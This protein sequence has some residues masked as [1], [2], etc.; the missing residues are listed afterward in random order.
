MALYHSSA[1]VYRTP[2]PT[3]CRAVSATVQSCCSIVP[4]RLLRPL[5][6]APAGVRLYRPSMPPRWLLLRARQPPLPLSLSAPLPSAHRYRQP[7]CA[8]SGD[9]R[10]SRA[11]RRATARRPVP[12][13]GRERAAGGTTKRTTEQRPPQRQRTTTTTCQRQ[14]QREWQWTRTTSWRRTR[15]TSRRAALH[16]CSATVRSSCRLSGH[17]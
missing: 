17:W 13:P 2:T 16:C 3:P 5:D 7:S 4:L 10:R 11:M 15:R 9:M 1:S 6:A 14:Q 8:A 12:V